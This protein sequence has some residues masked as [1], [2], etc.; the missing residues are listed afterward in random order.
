ME[1]KIEA[2]E[3]LEIMADERKLK[4]VMYNLLSNATKFTPDGGRIMVESSIG[5]E[6]LLVSI[7]DSGIGIS[8]QRTGPFI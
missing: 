6:G 1:V 7:K 5:T 4:Q 3:D 8:S 2:I